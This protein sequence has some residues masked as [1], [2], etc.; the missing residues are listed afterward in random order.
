MLPSIGASP[1]GRFPLSWAL[2]IAEYSQP[3]GRP[4]GDRVILTLAACPTLQA[5]LAPVG[6]PLFTY[7]PLNA[8][9]G[10]APRKHRSS[11]ALAAAV[12]LPSPQGTAGQLLHT[13]S[14]SG[15]FIP[16]TVVPAY[17][18]PVYASPG[19]LPY[20]MQDSVPDCWLCFVRAAISDGW[21]VCACKAQPPPNRTCSFPAYGASAPHVSIRRGCPISQTTRVLCLRP[22][23]S[24]PH[25]SCSAFPGTSPALSPP[26]HG[27]GP[28]QR[29]RCPPPPQR[30]PRPLPA[31][32]AVQPVP[33]R[34]R[35]RLGHQAEAW[36]VAPPAVILVVPSQLRTH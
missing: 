23:S 21:I 32:T 10:Y 15:L 17:V 24:P 6:S 14:I 12:I 2:P 19:T 31:S 29:V 27:L 7:P 34:A 9:R 3:V 18:L 4:R 1:A 25:P 35:C 16:F 36:A 20:T 33:P 8:C 13:C 22:H 28:R 26:L 5:A 11:L 30:S